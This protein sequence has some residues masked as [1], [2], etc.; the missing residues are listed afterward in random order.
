MLLETKRGKENKVTIPTGTEATIGHHTY[1]KDGGYQPAVYVHQEYPK[2]LYKKREVAEPA[3]VALLNDLYGVEE[4]EDRQAVYLQAM[5]QVGEA[6]VDIRQWPLTAPS[7]AML[8][9]MQSVLKLHA[10]DQMRDEW[11]KDH[12]DLTAVDYKK[13]ITTPETITVTSVDEEA[14]KVAEG[15][16]LTP[17]CEPVTQE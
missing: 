14:E 9:A 11:L 17:A 16:C 3:V 2:A 12:P 5:Q 13:Y 15:W 10:R 6:G 1:T 4:A 8:K 7:D